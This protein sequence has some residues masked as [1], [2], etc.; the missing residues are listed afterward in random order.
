MEIPFLAKN[1]GPSST[2]QPSHA[3]NNLTRIATLIGVMSILG[4]FVVEYFAYHASRDLILKHLYEDNLHLAHMI[5]RE[6]VLDR[7]IAQPDTEAYL[8]E[9]R[10]FWNQTQAEHPGR[11]L[12]IIRPDGRLLLNTS[13]PRQEGS[14]V[15]QLR[16]RSRTGAGPRT[17]RELAV[18]RRDW[19]GKYTDAD[20][21][22]HMA[23]I[24]YVPGL[25]VLVGVC[26]LS[27]EAN[28]EIR[29][30]T[31]PWIVG[32]LCIAGLLLPLSLGVLHRAYTTSRRQLERTNRE[33]G[34]EI[35]QRKQAEDRSRRLA[36]IVESS[37]DAIIR[38]TLGGTVL[39]WN[40]GATKMY[41]YSPE[42][43]K[44]RLVFI[45]MPPERAG[46]I[47]RILDRIG[48]GQIIEHFETVRV[49]K[50]GTRMDVSVS[51]SP[52]READGTIVGASAIARDITEHN[53]AEAA[54][55]EAE[56]LRVLT[57][58]AGAAAH[59]INQP[60]SVV[61]GIS[62]VLLL[63]MAA[64]APGRNEL[65]SIHRAGEEISRIV[66]KMQTV[67]QY[68]TR[69][70]LPGASIVDFEAAGKNGPTDPD[71]KSQSGPSG[72]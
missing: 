50:D 45:L 6:E 28:A 44:G 48:Q 3:L 24:A 14:N 38:A 56:R 63:D 34:D 29:Q 40:D 9:L 42:E 36:A 59:E 66:K 21:H 55:R 32:T 16:L 65:K 46:E 43:A 61:M 12:S 19:T 27:R 7:T 37:E 47:E 31:L 51:V 33:L 4:I 23:S 62:Q 2:S 53:K 69:P 11:F 13:F 71:P 54:T 60:L 26:A 20:G 35:V 49:H 67:R 30:I 10:S 41:G 1:S 52:I 57:E 70:Y 8:Q 15:G 58:T 68:A 25:N 17:I 18:S 22:E 5:G 72:A 39:D 64:D